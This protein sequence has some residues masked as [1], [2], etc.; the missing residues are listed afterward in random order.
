MA[1]K[2]K[3]IQRVQPGVTGGGTKKY[4]ANIVTDGEVTTD[5]LV[6]EIEKF[7]A[8]SEPDIKGVIVAL[9]NVIQNK[10]ADSKIVRLDKLGSFYPTL[11]STGSDTVEEVSL[12]NVK[13]VSVN[14]RA[15]AR[16]LSAI[17][18]AGLKKVE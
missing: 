9:E 18:D 15:G 3:P 7:S 17:K 5:D 13:K 11:S 12:H 1:I 16:I 8:L 14:Y 10:L 4:Y 6:K 2:W